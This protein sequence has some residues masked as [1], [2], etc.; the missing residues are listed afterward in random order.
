MSRV[1]NGVLSYGPGRV[2]ELLPFGDDFLLVETATVS[3]EEVTATMR[4]KPLMRI[5]AAHFPAKDGRPAMPI[6]PG[7]LLV[8]AAAQTSLLLFPDDLEAGVLPLNRGLEGVKF[9]CQVRPDC[10]ARI[11][12]RVVAAK[13]IGPS[14]LLKFQ[15][16]IWIPSDN[17]GGR[18]KAADGFIYGARQLS[19]SP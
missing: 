6:V 12:V 13:K 11:E 15:F 7:T 16:G 5:L 4:M 3:D 14:E 10:I 1:A 9:H 19:T 18:A 17:N 2:R 8:E